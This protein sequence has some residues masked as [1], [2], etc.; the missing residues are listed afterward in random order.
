MV[1]IRNLKMIGEQTCISFLR[2]TGSEE[3][4]YIDIVIRYCLKEIK[5]SPKADH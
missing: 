2:S 5:V 4:K 3:Q 1:L